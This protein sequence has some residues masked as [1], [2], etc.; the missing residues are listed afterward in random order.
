MSFLAAGY[1]VLQWKAERAMEFTQTSERGVVE[2]EKLDATSKEQG[3][4]DI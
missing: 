2:S 1:V 3:D 4:S